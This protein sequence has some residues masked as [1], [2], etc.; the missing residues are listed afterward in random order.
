[1]YQSTSRDAI[2]NLAVEEWLF[3]EVLEP[4]SRTQ[5]L[6]LWRNS[7]TVV[8]G[9]YAPLWGSVTRSRE[10]WSGSGL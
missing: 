5:I 7:P 4:A 10:D 3:N 2:F 9:K 6:Y 8:I 1:M